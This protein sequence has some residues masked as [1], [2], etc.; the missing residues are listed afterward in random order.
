MTNHTPSAIAIVRAN[1]V[2]L[3]VPFP[4]PAYSDTREYTT[5]ALPSKS[6]VHHGGTDS[7]SRG[8]NAECRFLAESPRKVPKV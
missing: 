8:A 3:I 6:S 1:P 4:R 5:R 7:G 2:S